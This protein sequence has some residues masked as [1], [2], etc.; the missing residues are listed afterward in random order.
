MSNA[1]KN[2][3]NEGEFLWLISLSDLMMLLFVFFVVM[4]SFS[5]QKLSATDR[6][7][8][9]SQISS[10]TA[11]P[12]LDTIQAKLLKWTVDQK[13]LENVEVVQKEDSLLIQ[14]KEG[15]LFDSAS[16]EI[17]ETSVPWLEAVGS[18]LKMIPAP[19]RIGIEG[20]TDDRPLAK[21]DNWQLSSFRALAVF[22]AL[23]LEE[24][25]KERAVIMGYGPSKPVKPNRDAAG[26]T[27]SENQQENR[28]VTIRIY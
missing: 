17:H 6:A 5:F 20:H 14:I 12:H 18:V 3:K 21:G 19:Y 10:P 16:Y 1:K 15:L 8:L 23:K 9:A 27:I 2:S 22:R 28:R 11:H 24:S 26:T 4:F 13:L 7:A 25:Q